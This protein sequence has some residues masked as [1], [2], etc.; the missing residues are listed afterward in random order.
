MTSIVEVAE[1][2]VL[3]NL[4]KMKL[5]QFVFLIVLAAFVNTLNYTLYV[6]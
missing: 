3:I 1:Y 5:L 6:F 4:G 2:L